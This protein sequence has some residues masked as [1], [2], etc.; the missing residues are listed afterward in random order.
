M[1]ISRSKFLDAICCLDGDSSFSAFFWEVLLEPFAI[2][3]V[4]VVWKL[5]GQLEGLMYL[6]LNILICLEDSNP[7]TEAGLTN[8]RKQYHILSTHGTEP[9]LATL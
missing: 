8:I 2:F 9:L 6:V 5:D 3:F 4:E 1:F 7:R